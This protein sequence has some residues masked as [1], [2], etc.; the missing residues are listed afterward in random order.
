M[1]SMPG[2]AVSTAGFSVLT[3]AMASGT[4]GSASVISSRNGSPTGS[5]AGTGGSLITGAGTAATGATNGSTPRRRPARAMMA[6][7]SGTS[8]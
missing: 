2:N 5:M 6:D 4:S 3:D 7:A 1:S 8:P